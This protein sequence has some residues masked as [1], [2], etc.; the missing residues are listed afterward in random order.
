MVFAFFLG[1][2]LDMCEFVFLL[3]STAESV[4]GDRNRR[5]IKASALSAPPL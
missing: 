4:G 2:R 5:S 3:S 1:E